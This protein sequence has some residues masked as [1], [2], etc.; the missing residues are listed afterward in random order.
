MTQILHS[1]PRERLITLASSALHY[2]VS[3]LPADEKAAQDRYKNE[4]LA[5]MSSS[6]L[7]RVIINRPT[8]TLKESGTNTGF[9][10]EYAHK[11]LCIWPCQGF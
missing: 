10:A 6:D 8:V 5:S 11:P 7:I 3:N 1:I 2:D 9:T 4:V